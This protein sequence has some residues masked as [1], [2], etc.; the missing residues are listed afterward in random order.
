MPFQYINSLLQIPELK[1]KDLHIDNEEFIMEVE[2]TV[3]VQPC[4]YCQSLSVTLRGIPY[5]RKVRHLPIFGKKSYLLLPAIRMSCT[6]CMAVFM[7]EY[8]CVLPRKRYTRAFE[9]SFPTYVIGSTIDKAAAILDVPY[10]TVERVYK[11]WMKKECP[12]LQ[13]SCIQEA[14]EREG[15]VLGIDDFAIRKGSTYNTGLHDLRGESL[16]D[17]LSGRTIEELRIA[18]QNHPALF[19][20]KPVA[21]VMD[22]AKCY[23]TFIKETYPDALRIADRF[24]VN[25]YVTEA[26]QNVRKEIQHQLP[27]RAARKIKKNFRLLAKRRDSLKPKESDL[28]EELLKYSALLQSVY[29]WK[30]AFIDWYDS[31]STFAHAVQGFERWLNQGRFIQHKAVQSCLKTMVN[32]QQEILNYHRLRFT[33]ATVEGR[34]NKIKALQRR[35]YFTRNPLY[36]KQRILLECNQERLA[37]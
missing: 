22:L 7:W 21:V 31:S 14:T 37:Y 2:P 9:D 26:L 30:E 20:L 12:S 17:I 15:L 25:R 33:N 4:P 13:A 23:H 6:D 19:D 8:E 27:S 32:W 10:S 16:L 28:L 1:V 18:Y 11:Q 3:P 29:E 5:E 24:H 35:H 36:Y 34:N